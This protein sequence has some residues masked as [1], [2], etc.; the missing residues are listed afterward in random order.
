MPIQGCDYDVGGILQLV[1]IMF[2]CLETTDVASFILGQTFP[3]NKVLN[4]CRTHV[5]M[6]VSHLQCNLSL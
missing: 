1:N 5:T 2:S 6:V 3:F 4:S